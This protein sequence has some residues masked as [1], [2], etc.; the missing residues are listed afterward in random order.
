MFTQLKQLESRGVNLK[1]AVNAP[2]TFTA[3]TDEL[4]ETGKFGCVTSC[5]EHGSFS[6]G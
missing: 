3:D 1:I 6:G 2:Q 4:A 5:L